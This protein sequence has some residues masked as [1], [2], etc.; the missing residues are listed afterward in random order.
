MLP[1][2][3]GQ[4]LSQWNQAHT[5]KRHMGCFARVDQLAEICRKLAEQATPNALTP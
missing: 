3:K 5:I 2:L 4:P 1:H